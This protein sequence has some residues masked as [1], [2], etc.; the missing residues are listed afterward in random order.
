[1]PLFPIPPPSPHPKKRLMY[2][3]YISL[4]R[5][6][7]AYVY[8]PVIQRELDVF[9]VTV[10]NNHRGRKQDKKEL[11]SGVPEHIY[12]F[13]EQYGGGHYGHAVQEEHLQEVAELSEVLED[14]DDYI[15]QELRRQCTELIP[16][17][18]DIKPQEA[19]NAYL[20]LKVHLIDTL[21]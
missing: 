17:T 8:I 13:P 5:D 2:S 7:L 1:M 20:Y 21:N 10:W 4:F 19:A 15:N 6:L 3:Q 9:R 16:D 11:P 18:N 14:T 12:N